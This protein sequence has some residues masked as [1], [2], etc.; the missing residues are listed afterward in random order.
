MKKV[1]LVVAAVLTL[2]G[3]KPGEDKAME[4]AKKEVAEI[5][6]DPDSAKFEGIKAPQIKDNDDGSVTALVCGKVN[7]KNGFGAYAGYR[8]FFVEIKMKS[9][10]VFSNSVSYSLGGKYL[11]T[12]DES[13]P[14]E[15]FE[16]CK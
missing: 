3:C 1:I 6:R 7:G 9:K 16:K 13:P 12:G 14:S 15:F 2:A 4:L 10:G 5:L 11:N 8:D